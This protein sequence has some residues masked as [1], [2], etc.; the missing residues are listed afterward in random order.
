M[1]GGEEGSPLWGGGGQVGED[2]WP[3]D[4]KYH[5]TFPLYKFFDQ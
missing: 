1:K 4:F 5:V 2:T 3:D